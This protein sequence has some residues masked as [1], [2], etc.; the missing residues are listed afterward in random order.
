M[1]YSDSYMV[2]YKA[3]DETKTIYNQIS[4]YKFQNTVQ[5]D[6]INY[7]DKNGSIVEVPT[8]IKTYMP[9]HMCVIFHL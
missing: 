4:L 7:T 1:Y 3:P 2:V 6:N 9:Y 5:T 8:F